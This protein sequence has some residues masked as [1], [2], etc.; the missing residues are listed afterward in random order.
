MAKK[1]IWK[2]IENMS[3][4]KRTKSVVTHQL[5]YEQFVIATKECIDKLSILR[6]DITKKEKQIINCLEGDSQAEAIALI[7]GL[8]VLRIEEMVELSALSI[9]RANRF[10][11]KLVLDV[12]RGIE[13]NVK[14]DADSIKSMVPKELKTL[15]SDSVSASDFYDILTK[16]KHELSQYTTTAQGVSE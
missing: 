14:Y 13:A 4:K 5:N 12:T 6:R 15:I 2:E 8:R 16:Y 7:L 9:I 3:S 10:Y 1:P 11:N